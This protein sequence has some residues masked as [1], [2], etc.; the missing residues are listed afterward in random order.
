MVSFGFTN[1]MNSIVH[2]C[3]DPGLISFKIRKDLFPFSIYLP[4]M[5]FTSF[6]CD[7]CW[8]ARQCNNNVQVHDTLGVHRLDAIE[9]ESQYLRVKSILV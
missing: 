7:S 6:L 2:K 1:M 9:D 5:T 8:Y 3:S 4:G